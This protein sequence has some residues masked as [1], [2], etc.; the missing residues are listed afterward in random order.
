MG[1]FTSPVLAKFLDGLIQDNL[2]NPTVKNQITAVVEVL[3]LCWCNG[4]SRGSGHLSSNLAD[5]FRKTRRVP[6]VAAAPF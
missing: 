3:R 1:Y 6:L 5:G 2:W 4:N